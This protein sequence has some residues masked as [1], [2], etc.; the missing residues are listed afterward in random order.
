MKMKSERFFFQERTFLDG[1]DIGAGATGGVDGF[2]VLLGGGGGS[3]LTED[4]GFPILRKRAHSRHVYLVMVFLCMCLSRVL[5]MKTNVKIV[6]AVI[7]S[8]DIDS[9]FYSLKQ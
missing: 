4:D 2:L 5:C 3:F 6:S 9:I 1:L 7:K 8:D